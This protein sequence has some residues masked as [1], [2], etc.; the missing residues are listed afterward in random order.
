[1]EVKL[2]ELQCVKFKLL[3]MEIKAL[4]MQLKEK[5]AEQKVV[6]DKI[7]ETLG[8]DP[9][10]WDVNLEACTAKKLSNKLGE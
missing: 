6:I 8:S 5:S 4:Q 7:S 9:K 2:D 10:E 1:M 3:S